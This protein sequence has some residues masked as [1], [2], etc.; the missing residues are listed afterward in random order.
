MMIHKNLLATALLLLSAMSTN[1]VQEESWNINRVVEERKLKKSMGS[2]GCG[3][4]KGSKTCSPTISPTTAAPSISQRPSPSPTTSAP[5]VSLAPTKTGKS[6]GK[7]GKR[8]GY[9]GYSGKRMGG[10]GCS[11][12]GKGSKTCSPTVS[13][14]TAAPSI[15]QRPSPSP[16]TSAPTLSLAPTKTGKS[17][18]KGSGKRRLYSNDA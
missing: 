11:G 1:A 15:S 14:T 4:G 6:K 9:D 17:K 3:K 16:T 2:K 12:K 10:K 5:S 18:G 13:P 7:G 8:D